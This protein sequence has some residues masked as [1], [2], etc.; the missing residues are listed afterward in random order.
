MCS[1]NVDKVVA[2]WAVTS[3][4]EDNAA[5]QS[6]IERTVVLQR[7]AEDQKTPAT[8]VPFFCQY[9]ENLAAQGH[10][11][12]A[13]SYLGTSEGQAIGELRFR[14][15]QAMT[16]EEKQHYQAPA[17]PFENKDLDVMIQQTAANKAAEEAATAQ[18]AAQAA[19]EAQ[20]AAA[21]AQQAQYQQQAQYG[22]QPQQPAQ[23][24]QPQPQAQYGQ[25]PQYGQP[26][27]VS[28]PA[29]PSWQQQPTTPAVPSW[30]QPQAPQQPAAPQPTTPAVPSWQQQPQAP[31]APQQPAAPSWQQPAAPAPT[32]AAPSWQQPVSAAPAPSYAT[33]APAHPAGLGLPEGPTSTLTPTLTLILTPQASSQPLT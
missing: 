7:A 16:N 5:L 30:Q 22:Q 23:Y 21:A 10:L 28:T 18:A 15:Y 20:Q 3:S 32:P 19:A 29:V 2:A 25:Q 27:P 17:F 4:T 8:A 24:G 26:A 12:A 11:G 31:Q 9:A 1:G 14:I 6:F 13:M 33:P